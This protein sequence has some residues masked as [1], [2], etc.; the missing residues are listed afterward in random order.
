M[1]RIL[2]KCF[3]TDVAWNALATLMWFGLWGWFFWKIFEAVIS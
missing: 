3:A 1:K 2:S